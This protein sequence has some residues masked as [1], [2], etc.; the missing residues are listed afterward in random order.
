MGPDLVRPLRLLDPTVEGALTQLS[1]A[2]AEAIG[3]GNQAGGA[4][5]ELAEAIVDLAAMIREN[6]ATFDAIGEVLRTPPLGHAPCRRLRR[7]R[8]G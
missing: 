5:R 4:T 7:M 1:N 6:Q 3:R 8:R 2:F